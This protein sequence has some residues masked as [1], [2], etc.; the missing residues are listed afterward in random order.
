MKSVFFERSKTLE[1]EKMSVNIYFSFT[2]T[3]GE[4]SDQ[5][6][7]FIKILGYDLYNIAIFRPA[8]LFL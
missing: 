7:T 5:T 3:A 1:R 2:M 4:M 6:V 8:V